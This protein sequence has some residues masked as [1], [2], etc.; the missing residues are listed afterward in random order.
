[1]SQTWPLVHQ[2]LTPVLDDNHEKWKPGD[3]PVRWLCSLNVP[4]SPRLNH[5]VK[6][7]WANTEET[8]VL[9]DEVSAGDL[10]TLGDGSDAPAV[11]SSPPFLCLAPLWRTSAWA[12]RLGW[13]HVPLRCL[14]A[15]VLAILSWLLL[16]G[17]GS[18]PAFTA[19]KPTQEDEPHFPFS[20]ARLLAPAPALWLSQHFPGLRINWKVPGDFLF[21][22]APGQVIESVTD[23]GYV[24]W[25]KNHQQNQRQDRTGRHW[26]QSLRQSKAWRVLFW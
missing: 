20:Q 22:K 24:H 10:E 14:L 3:C 2:L 5:S 26:K 16:E 25:A 21:F 18:L 23:P 9:R 19:S 6:R 8:A 12:Y 11:R 1:M 15:A 4:G 7:G 17:T 13:F